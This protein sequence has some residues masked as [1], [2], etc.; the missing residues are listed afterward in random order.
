MSNVPPPVVETTAGR[1]AGLWRGGSAAFLGIPFAEPPVGELR[2][3][4]PVPHRVWEGVREATAYGATP[5]RVA[6]AE[7]TAIPEPSIPGESTLNVNVFTPA[8]GDTDARLPV[9]VYIHGGGFVAGS[10]AS[11]WYDGAAFNR[12]GVVTVSVSYRL[13]FDGFGWIEDA[14][15]NRAVLDWLLALEWVR[16]NIARFGGDPGDVTIAGQSAGGGAVLTLLAVPRAA[17]LFQRAISISGAAGGVAL[18]DAERLGRRVAALAGVPPT[19]A[20]LAE[21]DEQTVL[22]LQARATAPEGATEDPLAGIGRLV[23]GGLTWSPVVDGDLL[24]VPV[25]DALR[26]GDGAGKPLLLGATDQEFTAALTPFREQLAAIPAAGILA[27]FG[28]PAGTVAAYG[29]AHPGSGTADLIGQF[30]TDTLFRAPALAISLAR[31]QAGAPTWLYRFAWPSG[32]SGSATHCLDVPF[33]FDGLAR[34]RV[35]AL[36][37]DTPPQ[38]LADDVHGAAVAFIRNGAPGWGAFT[39]DE[40]TAFVFDTPSRAETDAYADAA[41]LL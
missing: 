5:Q 12:D 10:P 36:A 22:E 6:L 35:D 13:D 2:F 9:L 26:R 19:R 32:V 33:W 24:P 40:R 23:S 15:V 30:I 41:S 39:A 7:V 21:V 28:V 25:L 14:P 3:A 16:D 8:P 31:A 17:Q 18:A 1:V 27:S 29:E 4:A 37:G 11:P 20:A 34:E 38:A